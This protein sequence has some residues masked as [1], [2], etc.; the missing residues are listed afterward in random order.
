M[1][2]IERQLLIEEIVVKTAL[3]KRLCPLG[4]A[5]EATLLSIAFSYVYR[6]TKNQLSSSSALSEEDSELL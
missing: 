4:S 6:Q 1:R 5:I 2:F 3:T